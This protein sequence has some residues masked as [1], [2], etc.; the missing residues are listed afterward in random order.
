MKVEANPCAA[1]PNR[2]TS[3]PVTNPA[4]NFDR[5]SQVY[6]WME[7]A[8]FGPFLWWCRC[9]FLSEMRTRN[10]ALVL[11]D[12]DGR[13]TARLLETNHAVRIN[14]ID[15][16][17][18]MLRALARRA[19]PNATRLRIFRGDIRTLQSDPSALYDLIVSHFFLDCLTTE[20]ARTLAERLRTSSAPNA[21]WIVSEF[22]IPNG[23]FGSLVARPIVASLYRAFGW[24]T[25]LHQRR[26]PDHAT[27]LRAAGFNLAERRK[28][29]YGLLVSELW[30]AGA[31]SA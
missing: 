15:A 27:A 11:G 24:L 3:N 30:Q 17:P 25:G 26:L 29:L 23:W 13:F 16:S 10:R 2:P 18:G 22:S 28:W 5:L 7:W 4:P 8:S 14:A 12:G 6:C 9:A 21:L 1:E 19:G 31:K 20:E